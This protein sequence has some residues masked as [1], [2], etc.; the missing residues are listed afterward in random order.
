MTRPRILRS[1]PAPVPLFPPLPE[2][3]RRRLLGDEDECAPPRIATNTDDDSVDASPQLPSASPQ[4][5]QSPTSRVTA[6]EVDSAWR[7]RT[8]PAALLRRGMEFAVVTYAVVVTLLL[9]GISPP[10]W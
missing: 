7:R 3:L 4:A 2:D 6:F 8:P 10:G 5:P 1:T 9:A